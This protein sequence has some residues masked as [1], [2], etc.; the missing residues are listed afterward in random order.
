V[1]S[2]KNKFT[3]F[4]TGHALVIQ[5][6]KN[7]VRALELAKAY[8]DMD[9]DGARNVSMNFSHTVPAM[10]ALMR[11]G[12]VEHHDKPDD[13]LQWDRIRQMDFEK[14]HRWYTL[15][16]A[17]MAVFDLCVIAGLIAKPKLRIA[18]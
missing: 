10:K 6:S 11:R 9:R 8:H 18:A 7:M 12:I 16:P 2:W 5:L 4:S 15:T 17:G 3:E 14:N 1:N 13:F